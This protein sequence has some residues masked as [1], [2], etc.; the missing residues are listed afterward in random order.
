MT[1]R[2][3]F[4]VLIGLAV[5]I[6]L[7]LVITLAFVVGRSFGDDAG[8]DHWL[9]PTD[10]PVDAETIEELTRMDLPEGTT[11][12]SSSYSSF[13]DWS[14][15]ATFTVPAD[16]VAAWEASLYG[17]GEPGAECFDLPVLS[18]DQVCAATPDAAYKHARY[19]RADQPDGSVKVAVEAYGD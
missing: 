13:Q 10:C 2:P 8:C 17:Y 9:G 19:A 3:V 16:G 5:A 1:K 4:W 14:L 7:G 11:L 15:D 6:L 12:E 18:E